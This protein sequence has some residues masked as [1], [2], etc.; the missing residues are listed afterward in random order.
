M[1]FLASQRKLPEQK[2]I[3]PSVVYVEADTLRYGEVVTQVLASGRISSQSTVELS[4]EVQGRLLQADVI[5]RKGQ[6]FREGQV[7]LTVFS[8]DVRLAL[9]SRKSSFLTTLANILPDLR[10]DFPQSYETW[11]SFFQDIS[12]NKGLPEIPAISDPKEKVFLSS[13]GI[14]TE[15]YA[16]RSE[17]VRLG[18][19][20]IR[21][22]FDGAI[23]E[24]YLEPGAVANPGSR[25]ASLIRTN[26]LEVEVPV[27]VVDVTHLQQGMQARLWM[28]GQPD[29]TQGSI[30]RISSFVDPATQSVPVFVSISQGAGS[31]ILQGQY[32]RVVFP[33]VVFPDAFEIPRRAVFNNDKIYTVENGRL[34]RRMVQVLH[35]GQ[36]SMIIRGPEE[37]TIIVSEPLINANENMAVEILH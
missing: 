12:I 2:A 20:I 15:Y 37:G 6:R 34:A 25:L 23:T 33:D 11:S 26:R 9:Q 8:E 1:N 32:M 22:P 13:R 31:S 27:D 10:I 5:F 16:I 28:P 17:E 35:V 7:L 3:P 24:V 30:L 18:K 21:A 14:L 29:P 4:S 36:T 19:Y